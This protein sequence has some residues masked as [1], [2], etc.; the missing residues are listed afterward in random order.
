MTNHIQKKSLV[1]AIDGPAGCGKSTVA[2]LIASELNALFI[3]TGAMYRALGL[4]FSNK[5]IAFE[6]E[7]Q[8]LIKELADMNFVYGKDDKI[9]VEINGQDFTDQIRSKEVSSLASKVSV[10]PE[11]RTYLVEVQRELGRRRLSVLEGRDIGTVIFPDALL[12]IFLTASSDIRGKRRYLQFKEQGKLDCSLDDIIKEIED[13]DERDS[14]RKIAP[15]K[16]SPDAITVDTSNLSIEEVVKKI[17]GLAKE[18]LN[19]NIN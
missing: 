19:E 10:I 13:R 2:K 9:L 11:I 15:L 14:T 6:S 18:R 4:F 1:V 7:N 12:K 17:V 16:A 8:N 5:K 3:D